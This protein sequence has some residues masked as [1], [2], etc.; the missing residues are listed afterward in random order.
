MEPREEEVVEI[1]M[2]ADVE[3]GVKTD[4]EPEADV[5]EVEVVVEKDPEPKQQ[6]QPK[7]Q[8]R[9]PKQVKT[10]LGPDT[11]VSLAALVYL[12]V[13]R[14]SRSVA[15]V[16]VRLLEMGFVAAGGDHRGWFGPN[17]LAALREFQQSVGVEDDDA[18]SPET[19]EAL[20][21]GTPVEVLP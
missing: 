16:Q 9:Q 3:E 18:A 14:N 17:T 15:A 12:A 4:P 7:Q 20:F 11:F 10:A 6:R 21:A 5:V 8:Q 19:I 2:A 13:A 1:E